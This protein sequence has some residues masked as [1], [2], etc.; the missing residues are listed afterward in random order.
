ME[1]RR[2]R[3]WIELG[4][5]RGYAEK[6]NKLDFVEKA[7]EEERSGWKLTGGRNGGKWRRSFLGKSGGEKDGRMASGGG[8]VG[9]LAGCCFLGN[10]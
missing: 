2:D 1:V 9:V 8:Q 7:G 4:W 6:G 5:R 3:V 10:L